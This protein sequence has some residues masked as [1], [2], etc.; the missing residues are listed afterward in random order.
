MSQQGLRFTLDVDGLLATD[1]A[2]V[3]FTLSQ[4]LSTPF[5]LSVDIASD[6]PDLTA[7]DFLEKNA[8]LT[9]WQGAVAL[10]YLHGIITGVEL[11][12]NNDWQMN[13]QLTISPPLWRAGLRQNFRIFQQQDIQAIAT[14]L[15]TENGITD[16]VPSFYEP[17]P[18][19]EFCVQYGET[20]LT[21][22][23]RLWAEEGI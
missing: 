21:F 8:T 1:T 16:W 15:L 11:R 13:Y 14:T 3:S 19:R 22:L 9:V 7:T 6:L 2:V 12:E 5:T 10:R 17:H 18:A 4:N 20:D 23:T